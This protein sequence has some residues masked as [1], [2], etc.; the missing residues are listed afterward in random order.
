MNDTKN[1]PALRTIKG[2]YRGKLAIRPIDTEAP[3]GTRWTQYWSHEDIYSRFDFAM[4]SEQMKHHIDHK[5]SSILA[6]PKNDPAS[7]HRALIISI[8]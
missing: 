2:P 7:D 1:S 6:V 4:F 5:I 3:D 8:K